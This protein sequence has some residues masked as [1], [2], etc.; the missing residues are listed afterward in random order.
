MQWLLAGFG[1]GVVVSFVADKA[2][3]LLSGLSSICR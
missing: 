2:D 3:S 1:C